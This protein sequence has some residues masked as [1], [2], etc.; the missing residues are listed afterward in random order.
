MSR[1]QFGCLILV[2]FLFWLLTQA[3][4]AYRAGGITEP[5]QAEMKYFPTPLV[6]PTRAPDVQPS[7]TSDDPQI[8]GH[9]L[10]DRQGRTY[11]FVTPDGRTWKLWCRVFA[12]SP[13]TCAGELWEE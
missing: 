3:V 10:M 8:A 13:P 6:T 2:F 4:P 5:P 9:Y 12:K 11:K 7:P 1:H